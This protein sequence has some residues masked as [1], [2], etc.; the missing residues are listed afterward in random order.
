[1]GIET[2]GTDWGVSPR[3]VRID[4]TDNL[5][6]ITATN[7]LL[8]QAANINRINF[9]AFEWAP[10]DS[11]L[12]N[13]S[14]GE[15]FFTVDYTVN[16]T[17]IPFTG[18]SPSSGWITQWLYPTANTTMVPNTGYAPVSG[19]TI[20]FSM[21]ATVAQG[22]VFIITGARSNFTVG[23]SGGQSLIYGSGGPA[24]TGITSTDAAACVILLCVVANTTF[25]VLSE[26]GNILYT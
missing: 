8:T 10:D 11:V 25:A 1:M 4:T 19:G 2:I 7:Y 23:L 3:T 17:F 20:A 15:G 13:Y 24:T 18:A 12:I 21:P 22:S 5:G 14:G 6:T 16:N 26:K 9:G